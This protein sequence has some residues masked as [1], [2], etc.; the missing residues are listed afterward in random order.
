[1]Y[2]H[3]VP[4]DTNVRNIQ[5]RHVLKTVQHCE[6]VCEFTANY[7]LTREDANRRKEQL[8]MLRDCADICTLTAKYMARHSRFA[9]SPASVCA[10]ICEACGNHCLRHPDQQSQKCGQTCLQCARECRE[11]AMSS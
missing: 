9:K 8:R 3:P 10:K 1:M 7:I 11:F 2:G 6:A 4:Y 5:N